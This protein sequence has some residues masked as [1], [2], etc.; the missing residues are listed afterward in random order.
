MILGDDSDSD[1]E[2]NVPS[3]SKPRL[4]QKIIDGE[5]W[6]VDSES[7][8]DDPPLPTR[9]T[10]D[11]GP[12]PSYTNGRADHSAT[13][14][15]T[16]GGDVDELDEEDVGQDQGDVGDMAPAEPL[17]DH[18][19]SVYG[20]D[21]AEG[22]FGQE[23]DADDEDRRSRH[24][25]SESSSLELNDSDLAIIDGD[26][27]VSG[28]IELHACVGLTFLT[29]SSAIAPAFHRQRCSV[30]RPYEDHLTLGTHSICPPHQGSN[31]CWRAD[32]SRAASG[33]YTRHPTTSASSSSPCNQRRGRCQDRC[34]YRCSI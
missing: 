25:R 5:L 22:D 15:P 16:E 30:C 34:D 6:T 1:V 11:D 18:A 7:L 20:E 24:S 31:L 2:K 28:L 29:G 23:D 26:T 9:P 13:V 27:S 14:E 4:Q 3:G 32:H 10:P 33:S 17:E 12:G 21:F 8:E 19:G